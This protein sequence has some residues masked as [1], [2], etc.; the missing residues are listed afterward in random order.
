MVRRAPGDKTPY[1]LSES[2]STT[3]ISN[4]SAGAPIG[5]TRLIES[6]QRPLYNYGSVVDIGTR[7]WLRPTDY[8]RFNK[9]AQVGDSSYTRTTGRLGTY[10]VKADKP[11]AQAF[12]LNMG[13]TGQITNGILQRGRNPATIKAYNEIGQNKAGLGEDFATYK[14]TIGMFT[15]K[16]NMLKGLLRIF[17]QDKGLRRYALQSVRQLKN[18]D[19]RASEAYLEHVYG[20]L[21]LMGDIHGIYELLLDYSSGVKPVIVVGEGKYNEK[22]EITRVATPTLYGGYEG[23]IKSTCEYSAKCKMWARLSSENQ[24]FRV[25]NQLGLLNPASLA[26][27]LM[28]WSFVVDWFIPI[29]PY[30]Q[31]L[32]STI[33][34]TYISGTTTYREKITHTGNFAQAAGSAYGST[35]PA[36]M[37]LCPFAIEES[38]YSRSYHLNWPNAS[39]YLEQNPFKGDRIL[40]AIALGIGTLT[41]ERKSLR[42]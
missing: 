7:R 14:Q 4:G 16:A 23:A 19:R 41:S 26:Y 18:I 40:K 8:Q 20:W 39:I 1:S 3:I 42:R 30:I 17:S 27:E 33:G 31:S 28:P 24:A 37:Q 21:P 38:T 10:E 5:H 29:G 25:L 32:S 34:L 2:G 9:V 11:S 22:T 36:S 6:D 12:V 15:S 35:D 13:T